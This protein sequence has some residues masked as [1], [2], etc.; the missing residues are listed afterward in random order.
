MPMMAKDMSSD[1]SGIFQEQYGH[2]DL[3]VTSQWQF[4]I[5]F[6]GFFQLSTF[7]TLE[8]RLSKYEV[9]LAGGSWVWTQAAR[10]RTNLAIFESTRT[11]QW[12][13]ETE[14]D[15]FFSS[16]RFFWHGRS[17]CQDMKWFWQVDPEFR[18]H[19]LQR[20]TTIF[21]PQEQFEPKMK[22]SYLTIQPVNMVVFWLL[23]RLTNIINAK[24]WFLCN[25]CDGFTNPT[26]LR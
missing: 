18:F 4:G 7:L 14:F 11:S 9:I 8:I 5:K 10:F 22:P 25:F 20:Q 24:V 2:F 19:V 26:P 6:D 15:D 3:I 13:S 17:H 1:T 23:S 16:Y 12:Q 21:L